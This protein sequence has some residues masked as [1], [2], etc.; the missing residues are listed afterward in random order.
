M[1]WDDSPFA[2]FSTAQPWLPVHPNYTTR[3]AALQQDDPQ[4]L[5]N[6]VKKLLALRKKYPALQ[7]GDFRLFFRTDTGVLA[8]ERAHDDQRV[9]V[10]INFTGKMN[11]ASLARDTDPYAAR[12]LLSTNREELRVYGNQLL[13]NPYEV[14][15]LLA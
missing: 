14:T 15:L 2:G 11:T 1:Q 3:N 7:R 9:L 5:F 6:F 8:Y 13:L 12:L 10:Y 4:S